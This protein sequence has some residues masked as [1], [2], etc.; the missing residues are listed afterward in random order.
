MKLNEVKFLPATNA[1][2]DAYTKATGV[3]FIGEMMVAAAGQGSEQFTFTSIKVIKKGVDNYTIEA[4]SNIPAPVDNTR[5]Y[6]EETGDSTNWGGSISPTE[7]G[8]TQWVMNPEY[9]YFFNE[10]SIP[11]EGGECSAWGDFIEGDDHTIYGLNWTYEEAQPT[12]PNMLHFTAQEANSTIRLGKKLTGSLAP[13]LY[14]STDGINFESWDGSEI[15]LENVGDTV[16]MYGNNVTFGKDTFDYTRFNMT[17][18]IAGAGDIT[19][20]FQLGG[21]TEF[22]STIGVSGYRG[23]YRMT[24]L[25]ASCSSLTSAPELPIAV[26]EANCYENMFAACSN[27]QSVTCLATNISAINCTHLWLNNVSATG[28]FTKSP[29]MASW[30]TG[31]SGIPNG[32][33]VEN[34]TI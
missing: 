30:T 28:T 26:L 3:P 22:P 23:G 24:R 18:L 32:W 2:A 9:E 15:T 8:S 31:A 16:W 34:K 27:L 4:T 17:G 25:F 10:G 19:Y 21:T 14:K 6:L 20:L 33:T 29:D 5:V 11:T 12:Y 1:V 7:E 13:V